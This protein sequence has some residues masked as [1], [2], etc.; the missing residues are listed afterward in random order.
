MVIIPVPLYEEKKQLWQYYSQS[1]DSLPYRQLVCAF[2]KEA[3]AI[4]HLQNSAV[5][6]SSAYLLVLWCLASKSMYADLGVTP[7]TN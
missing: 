7:A 1:N 6:F 4:K 5:V 2:N 3:R